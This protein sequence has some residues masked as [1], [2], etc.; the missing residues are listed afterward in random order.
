MQ[1]AQTLL[2]TL[3]DM[4]VVLVLMRG[5]DPCSRVSLQPLK[6]LDY[7]YVQILRLFSFSCYSNRLPLIALGACLSEKYLREN[8]VLLL[9]LSSQAGLKDSRRMM[10]S[11]LN[12]KIK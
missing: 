6:K 12:G 7:N 4:Y 9:V 1:D 5:L 11:H 2:G 8:K 10:L 3:P